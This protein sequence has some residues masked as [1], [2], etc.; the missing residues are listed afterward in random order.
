M[1]NKNDVYANMIDL[2]NK[3]FKRRQEQLWV[4][5]GNEATSRTC[6][7]FI[8]FDLVK[9]V[10]IASVHIVAVSICL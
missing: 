10:F 1:K 4:A 7:E 3:K 8:A 9:T 5:A 6:G 2:F